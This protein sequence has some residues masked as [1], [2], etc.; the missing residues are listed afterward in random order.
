MV[1]SWPEMKESKFRKLECPSVAPADDARKPDKPQ[2]R[3]SK[4]K[5]GQRSGMLLKRHGR[6]HQVRD[7]RKT[8][9]T[10]RCN[11]GTEAQC[12]DCK[13][14][15]LGNEVRLAELGLAPNAMQSTM[16]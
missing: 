3:E 5:K 16:R 12:D 14:V 6:K 9:T 2:K 4:C 15:L 1:D 8:N 11:I 10:L 13:K 7:E